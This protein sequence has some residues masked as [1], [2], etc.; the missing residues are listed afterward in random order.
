MADI[1]PLISKYANSQ[2]K[3]NTADFSAN[4][5][6]HRHLEHLSRAVWA[7]ATSG[8]ERG[9]HWYYERARGSYLDDKQRQGTKPRIRE[10]E[11]QNPARQKFT[12]TDLAKFEHAWMGLPHLVCLGAEKNFNKFAERM[13][14]DGE[15]LVDQNHF[16]HSIAKAILWRTAEK[17]FDTLKLEGYRANSVA[18][19]VA[20]MAEW[21]KRCIDLNRVWNDQHLS[22]A[23]CEAVKF[24]C[25]EAHRHIT[26]Q[27]G[28]PGEA[29][30]KEFCWREFRETEL[31][32]PSEWRE[33]LSETAFLP[34]TMEADALVSEWERIRHAFINDQ[35]TIEQLEVLTA[36]E[37]VVAR[38]HH[39]VHDY[40][41][42]TWEQLRGKRGMGLRKIRGLVELLSAATLQ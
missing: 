11:K 42:K 9:T 18:Y 32:E 40:A 38:R 29:S 15:P 25:A 28:N 16:K 26:A 14:E 23:L 13:E 1:V 33:E 10:W 36:R 2:N 35:R 27:E 4:G 39:V 30:K 8:L 22:V 5:M 21:S 37:W 20:W 17:L 12:K 19:A 31:S 41:E 7:P 6:F 24:V 34:A 3:V